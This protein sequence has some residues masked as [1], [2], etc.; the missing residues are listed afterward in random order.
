MTQPGTNSDDPLVVW[1]QKNNIP[2][3]RD[4]YIDVAYMGEPPEWDDEL[5][6]ALP[7]ELQRQSVGDTLTRT[8]AG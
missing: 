6:A 1:M 5:E 4:N 2:L 8:L 7:A 3:T